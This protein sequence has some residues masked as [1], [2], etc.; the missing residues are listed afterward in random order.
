VVMTNRHVA[1]VFCQ[2]GY[3]RRW[4]FKSGMAANIDYAEELGALD[5]AEFDL[6]SVIGV[7]DEFD[8][9]LFRVKRTSST[10]ATP[11]EPLVIASQSP[12]DAAGRNVYTVG[13]PAWDGRRNDPDVMNRIFTNVFNVKRLQPGAIMEVLEP[14]S[15]L[16]HDCS[17]LGGNSGSCVVDLETSQVVGLHFGGRFSEGNFAVALWKM[18][19]D[20]L[21]KKAKVNFQ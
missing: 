17:T 21:L 8:M 14:R 12:S 10:G 2:M 4:K 20:P 16:R 11:T 3:R 9:A 15:L 6:R 1:E 18:T 5:S 19:D 13:Y 7:H